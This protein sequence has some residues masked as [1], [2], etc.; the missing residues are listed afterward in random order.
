MYLWMPCVNNI[1]DWIDRPFSVNRTK[2]I[3]WS[4]R[5]N[6]R[7]FHWTTRMS[8]RNLQLLSQ[9]V[10]WQK[11][12]LNYSLTK[13][14]TRVWIRRLAVNRS[15]SQSLLIAVIQKLIWSVSFSVK[16]KVTNGMFSKNFVLF[17][18]VI[19]MKAMRLLSTWLATILAFFDCLICNALAYFFNMLTRQINKFFQDRWWLLTVT[20]TNIL[21]IMMKCCVQYIKI[22]LQA[23][24]LSGADK[25]YSV[26]SRLVVNHRHAVWRLRQAHMEPI[27]HWVKK[28]EEWSW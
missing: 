6:Q 13:F 25:T 26:L 27:I 12:R 21:L 18:V 28:I 14:A 1:S 19:H 3:R 10:I 23:V 8:K 15:W 4:L 5:L 22:C 2:M 16:K 7:I 24:K 17:S 9:M 11:R 20:Y